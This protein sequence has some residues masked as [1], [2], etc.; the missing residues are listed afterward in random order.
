LFLRYLSKLLS[1][2]VCCSQGYQM[3]HFWSKLVNF[4]RGKKLPKICA[5]NIIFTKS[6]QSN[7]R[8]IGRRKFAQS[9]HPGCS[10]CSTVFEFCGLAS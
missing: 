5:T 10:C 9:G 3:T 4:C 2:N 8:P 6:G 7:N 1:Q